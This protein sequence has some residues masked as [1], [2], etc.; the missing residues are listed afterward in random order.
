MYSITLL[1]CVNVD[2]H[3]HNALRFIL[4]SSC[5]LVYFYYGVE[6]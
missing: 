3:K 5:I 2:I 4:V 1:P 6:F